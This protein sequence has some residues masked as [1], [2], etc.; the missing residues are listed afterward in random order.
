MSTV[1]STRRELLSELTQQLAE[2]VMLQ[3][4]MTLCLE[5]ATEDELKLD[6]LKLRRTKKLIET[7]KSVS[8]SIFTNL[9]ENGF[10]IDTIREATQS[11]LQAGLTSMTAFHTAIRSK[12]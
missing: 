4:R 9:I 2:H 1:A 12:T 11:Q 7:S 10:T 3:T 6:E 5:R 8:N